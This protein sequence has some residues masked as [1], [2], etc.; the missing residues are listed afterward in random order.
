MNVSIPVF[1]WTNVK[2]SKANS[3][4]LVL[5]MQFSSC[6]LQIY[7]ARNFEHRIYLSCK[8]LNTSPSLESVDLLAKNA[9]LIDV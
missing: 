9:R 7:R 2:S 6:E 5:N 4:K 1:W 8:T 3:S